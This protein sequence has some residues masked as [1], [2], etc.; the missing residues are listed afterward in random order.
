MSAPRRAAA[1]ARP[2]REETPWRRDAVQ[3][4][5]W[6]PHLLFGARADRNGL[7]DFKRHSP[8]R[9]TARPLGILSPAEFL[10][11][12]KDP[13]RCKPEKLHR[14]RLP[15]PHLSLSAEIARALARLAEFAHGHG[16]T[17]DLHVAP[18]MLETSPIPSS[19]RRN[20]R[21]PS[22]HPHACDERR[23]HGGLA[24][25]RACKA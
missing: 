2:R 23:R 6:P 8:G 11:V 16:L 1:A 18:A 7:S 24:E 5:D 15:F 19:Y 13:Y 10:P 9:S 3:V 17:V 12:I 20:A 22:R 14:P 25:H 21:C 4:S